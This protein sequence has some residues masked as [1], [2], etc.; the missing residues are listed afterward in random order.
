VALEGYFLGK[1]RINMEILQVT[2]L[3]SEDLKLGQAK[4]A[5]AGYEG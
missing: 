3:D 5:C 2:K 1:S 4:C